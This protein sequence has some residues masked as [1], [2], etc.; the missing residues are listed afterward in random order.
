MH[1]QATHFTELLFQLK[2]ASFHYPFCWSQY[3]S[4]S[5]NLTVFALK[6][7]FFWSTILLQLYTF[8]CSTAIVR[9]VRRALGINIHIE[10]LFGLAAL[11]NILLEHLSFT[12]SHTLFTT[13]KYA[14]L[15]LCFEY[16]VFLDSAIGSSHSNKLITWYT[17]T[18][19]FAMWYLKF[20]KMFLL[21]CGLSFTF[22]SVMFY[23]DGLINFPELAFNI[24]FSLADCYVSTF[25]LVFGAYIFVD[26]FFIVKI[27]KYK[28][29]KA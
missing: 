16:S 7:M 18:Y 28:L 14:P 6:K 21:I 26:L 13:E 29:Q 1:L 25:S 4:F 19:S 20:V 22:Y 23:I 5:T 10:K 3:F 17:K 24:Y 12:A 2:P 27:F 15:T 8:L 9:I 11:I